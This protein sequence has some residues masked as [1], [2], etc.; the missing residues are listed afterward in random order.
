[1]L[2]PPVPHRDFWPVVILSLSQYGRYTI[3][4]PVLVKPSFGRSIP[5]SCSTTIDRAI[6]LSPTLVT[7]TDPS[8]VILMTDHSRTLRPASL[9]PTKSTTS[10]KKSCFCAEHIESFDQEEL[11]EYYR[12]Q[13]R[14][15]PV[16]PISCTKTGHASSR[17][18]RRRTVVSMDERSRSLGKWRMKSEPFLLF[19]L[20]SLVCAGLYATSPDVTS[21]HN[22]YES[23]PPKPLC[24][25]VQEE[26]ITITCNYAAAAA[27]QQD[28]NRRPRIVLNRFEVSFN[29][30]DGDLMH[31][32]LTFTNE[33]TKPLLGTNTASLA[34]DDDMKRNYLRR[35]LPQV[36][37]RELAPGKS[38]TYSDRLLVGSFPPGHYTFHLY[39][40]NPDPLLRLHFTDNLLL[41][42]EGVPNP[43]NGLNTLAEFTVRR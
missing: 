11:D 21:A 9:R 10:I 32:E 42:S 20:Q 29:P 5:M 34:I 8:G 25:T 41:S 6:G 35:E 15:V 39:I 14:Y 38:L 23:A 4:E 24:K 2:Y 43:A 18:K 1:M 7:S 26:R 16:V 28:K 22:Q 33:D 3:L 27:S 17:D 30:N 19:V 36:D 37:L 40:P 12:N 13:I 31:I